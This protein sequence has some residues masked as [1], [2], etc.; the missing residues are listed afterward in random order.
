[1]YLI[2]CAD[3]SIHLTTPLRLCLGH[4]KIA[5]RAEPHALQPNRL[6][7]RCSAGG[8]RG[9]AVQVPWFSAGGHRGTAV[10]VPGSL[11][12]R[13]LGSAVLR[14]LRDGAAMAYLLGIDQGTT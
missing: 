8:H 14:F 11:V 13:F 4:C 6:Q 2:V 10:Q 1:M 9:T 3:Y 5:P 12:P 7:M